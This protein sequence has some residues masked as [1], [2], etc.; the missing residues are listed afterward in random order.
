M[1]KHN[2]AEVHELHRTRPIHGMT[3][4]QKALVSAIDDPSIEQI[5]ITGPAGTGK[6]YISVGKAADYFNKN[7]QQRIIIVRPMVAN[8][9]EIGALPGDEREKS[10]P[11]AKRPLEIIGERIGKG[12]LQCDLNK[13]RI[14]VGILQMMQGASFDDT[15]LIVDEGQEMTK[16]QAKMVVTRMGINSKLIINGD[17]A[18]CNLL[19]G[20]GLK[21]LIDRVGM[22]K[23]GKITHIEFDIDDCQRSDVCKDWLIAFEEKP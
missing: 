12:K 9:S 1:A 11:W 16:E 23:S 3:D 4:N 20:S 2:H 8:G 7:K 5:I 14:E 18:Q 15:W 13:E 21:Y 17:I 22:H 6:S 19:E 10:E